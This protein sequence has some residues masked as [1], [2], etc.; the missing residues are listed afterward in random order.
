ML[1][2]RQVADRIYYGHRFV[3]AKSSDVFRHILYEQQWVDAQKH[4]LELNE[5][6]DC[7]A[8]FDKFLRYLYT[9]EISVNTMS[10]VG[11]LCLADKY[12][13][14]SLKELCTRYMAENTRS[15]KV[16]NALSWYSWAK[17]LHLPPLQDQCSKTIAWN[18]HDIIHS[19]EWRHMHVDYVYDL[20][21]SSELVVQNEFALWQALNTWLYVD[22][23]QPKLVEHARRL[24]PLIRFPQML[25]AQIYQVES[26]DLY[27]VDELRPLLHELLNK[28]YRFRALCPTQ[29]DT[30]VTFTDA[31]Y[32]PRDYKDLTVDT[33]RMQNTLR[34]GI[35]VD[36]KMYRGPVPTD[37][38][39]GEWKITY[40]KSSE[41]WTL[42]L[43]NHD[44]AMVNSEVRIQ[45]SI[46]VYN[47]QDNVIQVHRE[48]TQVCTR[49]SSVNI[50]LT[51]NEMDQAKNMSVLIK[52]VPL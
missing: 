7:E 11:I 28:A 37:T 3:L 17:A 31:Y 4:E 33:V 23:Q 36:V 51:I 52:P 10:A 34:F 9:A 8:V 19:P 40:R 50:Q 32:L 41:L 39:E 18:Y 44:T 46:I 14:D 6:S 47:E 38:R 43:Y 21:Q 35:Q 25:I 20:L 30:G 15:P 2:P 1:P 16:H 24:L 26:S 48:G 13:V 27:G 29:K 45:T 12:N 22:E 49:G 5:S 42:Q